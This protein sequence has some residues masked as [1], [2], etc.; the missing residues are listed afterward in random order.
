LLPECEA[1]VVTHIGA[2]ASLPAA[3]SAIQAW[4]TANGRESADY[5]W[6]AYL[7]DPQATPMDQ[8]RTEI[9]WPI[10]PL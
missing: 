4:L 1:A 9:V 3:H 2:Y 10:R 6:E 8:N 5:P 7:T